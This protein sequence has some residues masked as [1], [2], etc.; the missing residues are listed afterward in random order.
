VPLSE[1][2]AI[3]GWRRQAG[4]ELHLHSFA[5]LIGCTADRRRHGTCCSCRHLRRLSSRQGKVDMA[6]C[7]PSGDVA[8][9]AMTCQAGF[10]RTCR[11][12]VCRSSTLM[13]WASIHC[14]Q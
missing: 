7:L 13:R 4:I 1:L 5:A 12:A 14:L 10:S 8:G 9:R 3:R 11:M 2:S 6:H